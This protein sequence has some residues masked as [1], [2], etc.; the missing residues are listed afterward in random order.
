[1]E[2]FKRNIKNT[3]T[4]TVI[5]FALEDAK[6]SVKK[7]CGKA[8]TTEE[9]FK[10]LTKFISEYAK[11]FEEIQT[12]SRN[13]Y[14]RFLEKQGTSGCLTYFIEESEGL[15]ETWPRREFILHFSCE[16]KVNE[17]I[18]EVYINDILDLAVGLGWFNKEM[19]YYIPTLSAEKLKDFLVFKPRNIRKEVGWNAPNSENCIIYKLLR[20][21]E[22]IVRE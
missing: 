21:G 7:R 13:Y 19:G 18:K 3:T 16:G 4:G 6:L 17:D 15:Y 10:L 2:D 22:A 14:Y 9:F 8:P 11:E 12:C 5:N 20:G 1:M